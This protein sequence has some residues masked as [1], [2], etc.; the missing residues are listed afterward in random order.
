MRERFGAGVTRRML[1]P[2]V[3]G[4][5]FQ[6]VAGGSAVLPGSLVAFSARGPKAFT[7]R[8]GLG[9]LTSALAATLDVEYDVQVERVERP[10]SRGG[11][12]TLTTSRGV[13]NAGAVVITTP[14]GPSTAMLADPTPDEAA[15]LRTS[16]SSVV[17]VGLALE[18][19]LAA[20]ELG[21][22]YGVLVSPESSSPLA[23][24][25][26]HSRA[27]PA[28]GGEVITVMFGHDA[29][30]RLMSADD[31]TV[32]AAAVEALAPVL[33]GLPGR[34]TD[35]HIARWPEA[36]P[37]LHVGLAAAVRRYR[38]RLPVGSAVLLAGDH[39]GLPWSD[40]AAFNGRWAADRLIADRAS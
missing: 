35:S 38:E 29:A 24:L 11:A 26:V 17:L 16:Y 36:L 21:G 18:E 22:A 13:R 32:R 14:A 8:G 27:D 19:R 30:Q 33:P 9:S 15:V 37:Y 3:N 12:V 20:G 7:L 40:A 23:A 28:A 39:L 34:V 5:F 2:T 31:E 4:L 25:A 10:G 1:Q 6:D